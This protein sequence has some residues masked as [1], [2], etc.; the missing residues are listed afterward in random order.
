MKDEN[1]HTYST[2][3][4]D[5][6]VRAVAVNRNTAYAMFLGAGASISSGV[7]SAG[8][9]IWEWKRQI[10]LTKNPGLRS[11]IGDFMLPAV[12]ERI[13]KWL[14]DTGNAPENIEQEYSYFAEKCFPIAEDRRRFFQ[15]LCH[16]AEPFTGYRVLALLA[17]SEII[18]SV[19]TTNFDGLVAKASTLMNIDCV[20]IETG[21]ES[22]ERANR[23]KARGELLITALHGDYRYGSLKNTVTELQTQDEK[24]RS[25][26]AHR[27]ID[28]N[29]IVVGFSGRDKSIMDMLESVYSEPERG[30]LYWCGYGDQE[31]PDAVSA[32]LNLANSNG[33]TAAYIRTKGFDEIILRIALQCF[34]NDPD[35]S[36]RVQGMYEAANASQRPEPF[37]VRS[38]KATGVVKSN[39]FYIDCPTEVF[40]FDAG[41]LKGN[42]IWARLREITK[43]KSISCVPFREKILAI[44]LIDEIRDTFAPFTNYNAERVPLDPR[45]LA[46]HESSATSL[47]SQAILKSIAELRKLSHD[48]R[49][50]LWENTPYKVEN[51][52][53]KNVHIHNA[54]TIHLRRYAGKQYLILVP[55]IKTFFINNQSSDLETDKEAKRKLLTGQ[56]NSQFND[57]LNRWRD[58]LFKDN[59]VFELPNNSGSTFRFKVRSVPAFS[60]ISGNSGQPLN[61]TPEIEKYVIYQGQQ[62]EEPRLV[63]SSANGSV[64]AL[65]THSLRG[66]NNNRPFDF[67][68]NGTIFGEDIK[69]GI[70]CPAKDST[71]LSRF[72]TGLNE[73]KTKD[74]KDEYLLD[75]PGFSQAFNIPLSIP[76]PLEA[77]WLECPEPDTEGNAKNNALELSSKIRLLVNQ[78]RA[79]GR[80]NVVIVYVPTRWQLLEHFTD[81]TETFDLHDF[82]KAH[83]VMTGVPTQFIRE[84]TLSKAYQCEIRWWLALSFYVKSF[85]TPWILDSRDVD[86]ETAFLGLGFRIDHNSE[87]GNQIVLGCSHIYSSNGLGL[88]YQLSK[89][90]NPI[91]RRKNP[92]MSK[93]DARRT[94]ESVRRLFHESAGR[95]P[96]RVVIHKR[97]PFSREEKEGLIEGLAGIESIDMLE[98]TI[99]PDLRYVASRFE[100]GTMKGDGFP[101]RRGTAIVLDD[102]HGLLWVHGSAD[103]I[104]PGRRYYQGKSRIPAPLMI[105]RHYGSSPFVTI[106]KEILGLSKMDWNTF[107]LYKKIPAT[108]ASS[109]E[110]AK[111]GILLERFGNLSY[112]YRLFI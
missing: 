66:I 54:V 39:A 95:L 71:K 96:K 18:K 30:R 85:R 47:L 13:Q 84:S 82:I 45:E 29:L 26:L 38:L 78:L 102:R 53:G 25:E 33:R 9:C 69:L 81:G 106:C 48:G 67:S 56:Y 23:Q 3:E 31:P 34:E 65:D 80:A 32:L 83:G 68:S 72:L 59:K 74:S 79:S 17:E 36:K 28:E 7:K 107:D 94:G 22:V 104:T 37:S 64:L 76:Q 99:D 19:W 10:F 40:Q 50:L 11:Q 89:L 15:D 5:A 60:K 101:V 61:L 6:F 63:F 88:S 70:I 49:S 87:R 100:N 73:R 14:E 103:A 111:I 112:D 20:A 86:R 8:D 35:K 108:I 58:I 105:T 46:N 42:D 91:V 27:C 98:I 77:G 110:I 90:E 21:L 62:V 92:Y 109:N 51:I 43:G 97:T 75:Y 57:A 4:F 16:K 93:E 55:T 41:Q 12:K 24:L 1:S 44:G 2:L 52:Y